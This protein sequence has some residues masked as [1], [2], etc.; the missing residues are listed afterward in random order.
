LKTKVT[1]LENELMAYQ[2]D[3]AHSE[4]IQQLYKQDL[5]QQKNAT[6]VIALDN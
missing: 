1:A 5:D 4:K 2:N 6:S 3:L